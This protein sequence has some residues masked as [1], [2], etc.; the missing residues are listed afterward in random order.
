MSYLIDPRSYREEKREGAGL[1]RIVAYLLVF[2]AGL[3]IGVQVEHAQPWPCEPHQT[4]TSSGACM[5]IEGEA[6]P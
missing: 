3:L 4:L 5:A 2:L 1:L 6:L